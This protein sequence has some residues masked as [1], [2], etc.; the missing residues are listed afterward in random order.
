MKG[1]PLTSGS[2]AKHIFRIAWP[3]SIGFFFNT[4]YNVVDSFYAGQL[5]TFALSAMAMAFPVFFIVIATGEGLARGT[6]VLVANSIGEKNDKQ[7]RMYS[8][9]GLTLAVFAAVLLSIVGLLFA[10]NLFALMGASKESLPFALDYISPIFMGTLF[11]LLSSM[12][13]S[14]LIAHGD[15]K[16]FGK[17]L[18]AGFFLNLLLNPWF[19][20]GGF[21][22]PA[23]GIAGIGWATVVIQALGSSFLLSVIFRKGYLTR[24]DLPSFKPRL[25]SFGAILH[26][27]LP[28]SFNMMSV[29]IG[30]FIITYF[31]QSY[32]DP[33]VAAFGIGTRIEQIALLP[34]IGLNAAIISIV[35]QNNGAKKFHRVKEAVGKGVLYG[36]ILIVV[37]SLLIYIFARPLVGVFTEDVEVIKLGADYVAIM[38]FIQWA[39][40]MGFIHL[41]FL[42]AIKKPMY[43]FVESLF[44]K[45]I[46]PLLGL[47]WA[48]NIAQVGLDQ[49]W[50]V[51]A[52]ITVSITL[53]T[54]G[55]AQWVLR[56]KITSKA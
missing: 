8:A 12:A 45:V 38:A 1:A 6:S 50:L 35:G 19:M 2:I 25:K 53:I 42:Q 31:L 36:A 24:K 41:G 51:V 46:I 47:Y 15:S 48:V 34:A 33:A 22:L 10:E 55:Y 16:T 9:Q 17:V 43:G 37:M 29:A 44:R 39:Y 56:K 23:L 40:V 30:F 18:V 32:G 11:F 52:F 7:E 49:Y 3:I 5:S 21:G 27:G 4:M 54:I 20:Y 14:V 28:A 13:N 26:Q